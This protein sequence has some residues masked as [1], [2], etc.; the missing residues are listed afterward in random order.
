MGNFSLV[1]LMKIQQEIGIWKK[2]NVLHCTSGLD[3]MSK[4]WL[5]EEVKWLAKRP[6]TIARRFSTFVI[7]GYKFMIETNTKLWSN[8][9]FINC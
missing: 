2:I 4:I 5:S 1:M 7:N 6:N 9:Y 3:T 8:G